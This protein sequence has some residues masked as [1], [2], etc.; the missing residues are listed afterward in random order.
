MHVKMV[1]LFITRKMHNYLN[2]W[3]VEIRDG[4]LE[5]KCAKGSTKRV[6]WKILRYF[7]ITPRLQRLFMS[8]K[9]AADMR[10]HFENRVKDGL[11]RHPIDC[12]A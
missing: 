1:V 7:P 3:F 5:E 2:V 12:E 4:S 8:S 11:L 6:P 10:W 9:T